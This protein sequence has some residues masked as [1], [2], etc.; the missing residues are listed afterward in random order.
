VIS[1][2]VAIGILAVIAI[3]LGVVWFILLRQTKQ[4]FAGFVVFGVI[5]VLCYLFLL[6]HVYVLD[7]SV[8]GRYYERIALFSSE[9]TFK[10]G[11]SATVVPQWGL[12]KRSIIL[13]D[14][15]QRRTFEIVVYSTSGGRYDPQ[16]TR[17]Q[18]YSMNTVNYSV[19]YI[20]KNPP[21]SI[22]VK[23]NRAERGWIH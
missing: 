7:E 11:E 16:K 4:K 17:L 19:D 20:Y 14:T 13:N 22:R 18:P 23:G 12:G 21:S 15:E 3:I 10:N 5:A 1:V 9:F 2:G 6:N 8:E